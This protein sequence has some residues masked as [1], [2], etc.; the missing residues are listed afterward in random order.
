MPTHYFGAEYVHYNLY[1]RVDGYNAST[2][3]N[4]NKTPRN[5]GNSSGFARSLAN[6]PRTVPSVKTNG[7]CR[8]VG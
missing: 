6:Y 7:V 1:G 2:R 8:P 3:R 4:E 5:F